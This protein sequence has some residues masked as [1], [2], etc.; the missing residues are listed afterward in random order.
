MSRR[1]TI[2]RAKIKR[3]RR[4]LWV[5]KLDEWIDRWKRKTAEALRQSLQ[6]DPDEPEKPE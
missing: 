2:K 6:A 4:L 3:C 5:V 1:T